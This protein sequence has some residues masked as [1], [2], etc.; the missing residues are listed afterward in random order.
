[1]RK[2][3]HIIIHHSL[4]K[5]GKTVNWKAIRKYHTQDKGWSDIGYHYGIEY[6]DGAV[7]IQY[8]R[9]ITRVGAHVRGMNK[10]TIGICVVGNYDVKKPEQ[11]KLEVLG[12]VV[13]TLQSAFKV[14]RSR[15]IG[16][17]EAQKLQGIKRRKSCPGS[18]FD[19]N[20]FRRKYAASR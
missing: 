16:H 15:V 6:V 4:T 9:P 20:T 13:R 11:D 7:Q 1:V 5:D 17:W 18:R 19:M 14:P 2:I 10:N 8:G 12:A 3:T